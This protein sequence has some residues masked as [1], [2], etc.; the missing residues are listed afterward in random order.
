MPLQRCPCCGWTIL[1]AN[2]RSDVLVACSNCAQVVRAPGIPSSAIPLCG[3]DALIDG[4]A[5]TP[6]EDRS[7]PLL[8]PALCLPS[9]ARRVD[10]SALKYAAVGLA[11]ICLSIFF[12]ASA[13]QTSLPQPLLLLVLSICMGGVFSLF[14]ILLFYHGFY[15]LSRCKPAQS[16]SRSQLPQEAEHLGTPFALHHY[17][18]AAP[19][20]LLLFI[21]VLLLAGAAVTALRLWHGEIKDQ[22]IAVLT[23][24]GLVGGVASLIACGNCSRLQLLVCSE[25]FIVLRGSEVGVLWRWEDIKSIYVQKNSKTPVLFSYTLHRKDRETFTFDHHI[26]D[27]ANQ[28]GVRVQHTFCRLMLPQLLSNLRAGEQAMFG[29]IRVSS[30]GLHH[31]RGL[32]LWQQIA[33]LTLDGDRLTIR[34]WGGDFGASWSVSYHSV[35]NL[36]LFYALAQYHLRDCTTENIST[37]SVLASRH[38]SPDSIAIQ[39]N[40]SSFQPSPHLTEFHTDCL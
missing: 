20:G 2:E 36:A 33:N 38:Q 40:S 32:V 9:S 13:W 10:S 31:E 11:C 21:G 25:G 3:T 16:L 34:K 8:P 19:P 35:P 37:L 5:E 18:H 1:I 39:T 27:F 30:E 28:F 29:S 14:G 15:K 22:R 6:P 4:G 12:A 26:E 24:C 17:A 7:V 23:F